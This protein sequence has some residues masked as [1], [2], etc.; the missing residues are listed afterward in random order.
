MSLL[1]FESQP[2]SLGTSQADP[3]SLGRRDRSHKCS[4]ALGAHDHNAAQFH[5]ADDDACDDDAGSLGAFLGQRGVSFAA[6]VDGEG[7]LSSSARISGAN[8]GA[9]QPPQ[10][11]PSIAS[12]ASQ[13][14]HGGV[15]SLLVQQHSEASLKS[16]A[17]GIA[18]GSHATSSVW[19]M[20]VG[21]NG[22]LSIVETGRAFKLPTFSH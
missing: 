4:K 11:S 16:D 12:A 19:S 20:P 8:R 2:P 3:L 13:Q 14:Q 10:R 9:H 15:V 1:L 7:I 18:A 22:H 6:S 21:S 5:P 17:I